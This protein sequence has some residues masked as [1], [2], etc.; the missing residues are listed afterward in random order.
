MTVTSEKEPAA[1][2]G[3][4]GGAQSQ[5]IFRPKN[6]L[7]R[8]QPEY[9]IDRFPATIGRHPTNDVELPFD[10]VSRF[11]ARLEKH[12]K[13]IRVIDLHSS[14]GTFVNSARVQISP[15]VEQDLVGFGGIEMTFTRGGV[16]GAEPGEDISTGTSVHFMA[17]DDQVVKSIIEADV[18]D[19]SSSVSGIDEDIADSDQLRIAKDRL[20]TFYKLHEVLRSTTEEKRLLRRV[21]RLLFQVLPVDRGV[22]LTRD[23]HDTNLFNP[24]A[25]QVRA[26]DNDEDSNKKSERSEKGIGIS[27]TILMRCLKDKV[28]VLTTDATT[29]ER[30]DSSDS[31]LVHQI[32]SAMCVPLISH[33]RV[34]GFIHLDTA[35]SIRAFSKDDLKF[36]ANVGVE[37]AIHLHNIRMLQ[38]R[39]SQ[40]R[41]AAIGQTITGLAHN[42]KN[43]L[44]L[45]QGGVDLMEK[46][47]GDKSYDSI[48]ETWTL[49]RRGIDRINGM[50]KE[51]L[52]YSRARVAE[53]TRC[54][55]NEL[56]TEIRETFLEEMENRGV[57]CELDLDPEVPQI[58][59]DVDGLD[60][61]IV[62]LLINAIE[63]CPDGEGKI[64]LSTKHHEDGCLFIR[65]QDN[66]GGIPTEMLP[67]IFFPFFTT[68]GSKGSG[69]GLAMTKKFVEDMGG[70]IDVESAVGKGTTFTVVIF[71]DRSDIRLETPPC[72][73]KDPPGK[74]KDPL[75]ETKLE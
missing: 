10:S 56:L 20:V 60:K 5:V 50:V 9:R 46:R 39:I 73:P 37:V 70:R 68:K 55:V 3:T 62:N 11:H 59:I 41:M 42:I 18:R 47:L 14:N 53:K 30:F 26:S 51:M 33:H 28:A 4:D 2:D 16:A 32:H 44:L 38:D 71:V 65:V 67:R 25:V 43:V 61:A 19:D 27:K 69:L 12:G 74:G 36:L 6:I 40:E 23:L 7:P 8:L 75:R 29:D 72:E 34:F 64:T 15:L 54:Q 35:T 63:E 1:E 45:S 66:A 22:V 21:L 31:I 57:S 52:D 17:D 49:V 24:A 58:M 13:E 48:G